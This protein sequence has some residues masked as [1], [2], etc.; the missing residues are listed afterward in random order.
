ME[1]IPYRRGQLEV[2]TI[3]KGTLLF[4]LVKR[5]D[6]DLRGVKLDDGTRCL[7]P[8]YNVFF[9]PNPFVG[10][11]ALDLWVT[12]HRTVTVYVLTNDVKVLWLLNP[13][14]Y[15]RV[16]KSTQRTFIKRCSKVPQ[17]CLPKKGMGYNPCMSDTMIKKYPDIVGMM[18]IARADAIRSAVNLKRKSTRRIRKYIKPAEDATGISGVPEMILH[19]LTRRLQKDMIVHDGDALENNYKSIATLNANN[20]LEMTTFMDKHTVYNPETF[21]YTYK[22]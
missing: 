5:P 16:T 2:K 3:P 1:T 20:E 13:S 4:R 19:P 15:S 9:Y 12:K 11:L 7:T 17:G 21:F 18:A 10:K 14:K 22:P 8:N 6:D